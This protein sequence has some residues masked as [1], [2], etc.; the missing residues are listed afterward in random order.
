MKIDHYMYRVYLFEKAG[1]DVKCAVSIPIY[2]IT[3]HLE[4]FFS[5]KHYH[6]L[7][8]IGACVVSWL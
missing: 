7:G 2:V 5:S 3:Q 8:I 4:V 1:C 6:Q